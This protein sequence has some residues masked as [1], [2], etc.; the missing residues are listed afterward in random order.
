M[1]YIEA[2]DMK[3]MMPVSMTPLHDLK[4]AFS[5]LLKGTHEKQVVTFTDN[6]KEETIKVRVRFAFNIL[7]D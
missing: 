6:G 3:G 7:L 2:G 5:A 4:S 1:G